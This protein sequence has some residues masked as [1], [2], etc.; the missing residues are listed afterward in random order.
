M[1]AAKI[2]PKT[3]DL[4]KFSYKKYSIIPNTDPANNDN[5]S[6]FLYLLLIAQ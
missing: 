2:K 3:I 4:S 6:R 1:I 5:R